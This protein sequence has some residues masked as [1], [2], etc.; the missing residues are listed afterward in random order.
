MTLP[1]RFGN[2]VSK[3]IFRQEA[4]L[5]L[6]KTKFVDDKKSPTLPNICPDRDKMGSAGAASESVRRGYVPLA[7]QDLS[8]VADVQSLR[9]KK[10]EEGEK[11]KEKGREKRGK[12]KSHSQDMSY[13][14]SGRKKWLLNDQIGVLYG[15]E[16]WGG[17]GKEDGGRGEG[18]G[19]EKGKGVPNVQG[20]SNINEC[21]GKK[22]THV[23]G[24]QLRPKSS[25]LLSGVRIGAE[26]KP[27]RNDRSVA[28]IFYSPGPGGLS[29]SPRD[30]RT[31]HRHARR[32][33]R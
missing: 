8:N 23:H 10:R 32:L 1:G 12:A 6:P 20:L 26:K 14:D 33:G 22:E 31:R 3:E 24:S 18:K 4:E 9:R 17:G 7:C 29:A 28:S 19:G 30:E 11:E 25:D 15:A 5:E 2:I 21:A 27:L 13:C 16:E